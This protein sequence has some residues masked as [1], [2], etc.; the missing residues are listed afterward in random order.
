MRRLFWILAM[1]CGTPSLLAQSGLPG[2]D[3]SSRSIS[4]TGEALQYVVPDQAVVRLGIETFDASL[5][6]AVQAGDARAARLVHAVR[7]LG[8]E[9][10]GIQADH[11]EVEI[12]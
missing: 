4:V 7:Q 8:V 9:E 1:A 6:E 12:V 2:S 3:S 11:A 5:E 10:R